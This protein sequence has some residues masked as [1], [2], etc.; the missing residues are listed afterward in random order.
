ME[1][2][3]NRIL[4]KHKKNEN[5]PFGSTWMELK[6]IKLIEISQTDKNTI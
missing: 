3:Q 5:L 2:I 4:L 1:Y 6:I